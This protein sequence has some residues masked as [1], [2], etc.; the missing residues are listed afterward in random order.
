MSEEKR[1]IQFD[2]LKNACKEAGN[3]SY[4]T[5][6]YGCGLDAEKS[7]RAECCPIWGGLGQEEVD[8]KSPATYED[9]RKVLKD[10]REAVSDR[11]CKHLLM[12]A[13]T[14]CVLRKWCR[15]CMRITTQEKFLAAGFLAFLTL[16][17]REFEMY[18]SQ[19]ANGKP[20]RA[21]VTRSEL[22]KAMK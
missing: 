1:A 9:S 15:D 3:L 16:D 22:D 20:V 13:A 5:M 7:C 6:P 14:Y 10:I 17:N 11:E 12:D 2:D 19:K 18:V 21:F 4:A 8:L